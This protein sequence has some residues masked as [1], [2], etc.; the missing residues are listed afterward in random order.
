LISDAARAD[1]VRMDGKGRTRAT[2]ITP[3]IVR[4]FAAEARRKMRTDEGNYHRHYIQ[5]LTQRV[6]VGEAEVRITGSKLT[7]LRTLVASE[8]VVKSATNDV[9]SF[10]PKWLPG[11]DSRTS[12]N[13]LKTI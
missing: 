13:H 10:V 4:K 7:L 12:S 9:R 11:P 8:P 1:V 5:A 6:D 2:E 3:D